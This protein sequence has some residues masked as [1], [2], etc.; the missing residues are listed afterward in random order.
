[1][2]FLKNFQIRQNKIVSID[3][4][5]Y[6]KIP[7]DIKLKCKIVFLALLILG[8]INGLG[9]SDSI[10]FQPGQYER[11]LI[12][13]GI[14]RTYILHIPPQ[15]NPKKTFPL[16][17]LFHGGGGNAKQALENYGLVEKADTEGFILASLNGTGLL[18]NRLLTWN[19]GFGF[20]YAMRN[21]LDDIGFTRKVIYDIENIIHIDSKRIYLTGISNGGILCHFLAAKLSDKI[22]AISPIVATVGG[23]KSAEGSCFLPSQ[24]NEAVSVIAFNGLLDKHIP[25]EG[26]L[27][28]KSVGDPVWVK[29]GQDSL[30]FW[31]TANQCTPTPLIEINN[32]DEYKKITYSKCEKDSAVVQYVILNQGH[33]WPGGKKPR[34]RA[35][36]P[37]QTVHATDLMWTFFKTHP[38]N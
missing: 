16:V 26:G 9:K 37:S 36:T 4:I 28:K 14:Q 33:A 1:M 20:G 8:L 30:A 13:D 22:A 11:E 10:P 34:M 12:H 31:V 2:R 24:P 7:E 17:L 18:K 29:S 35:D 19:V 38:K 3:Y 23:K 5:L 15:Y 21:N 6:F 32:E 25:F 27:Q